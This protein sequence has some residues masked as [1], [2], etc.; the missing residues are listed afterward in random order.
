M[1]VDLK[2]RVA[3]GFVGSIDQTGL[4]TA[5]YPGEGKI[6]A[7]YRNLTDAAEVEVEGE[8]SRGKSDENEDNPHVEI[9]TD[10]VELSPGDS[11]Q[12]YA[13]FVDSS[14]TETDSGLTWRP[15]LLNWAC[16]ADSASG[17]FYANV[18]GNGFIYAEYQGFRDRVKVKIK[19]DEPGIRNDKRK[20]PVVIT[21]DDTTVTVGAQVSYSV[22][23]RV[24]SLLQDTSAVWGNSTG[25]KVGTIDSNGACREP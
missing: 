9:V 23:L 2:W 4:F 8:W 5:K 18:E 1:D 11:V 15:I 19:D 7:R 22:Q 3:P 10:R 24:D 16:S 20:S 25:N 12:L 6:V 21:P 17:L 14:G 13:V